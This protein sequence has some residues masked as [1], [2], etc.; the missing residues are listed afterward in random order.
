MPLTQVG[1]QAV[2]ATRRR[3]RSFILLRVM[4]LLIPSLIVELIYFTFNTPPSVIIFGEVNH[5]SKGVRAW[6]RWIA[7]ALTAL[8]AVFVRALNVHYNT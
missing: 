1:R 2:A 7:F 8:I 4:L 6:V 3:P 5:I